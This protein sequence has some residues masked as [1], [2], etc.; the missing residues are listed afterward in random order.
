MVDQ[1]ESLAVVVGRNCKDIRSTIGATQDEIAR[2]ARRIGLRWTASTVGDFEAGRSAPTFATVLAVTLALQM[3]L[4]D[5][6]EKRGEAPDPE[7]GATLADLLG[8]QGQVALTDSFSVPAAQVQAVC[9]GR[10]FTAFDPQYRRPTQSMRDGIREAIA[11]QQG[12]SAEEVDQQERELKALFDNSVDLRLRSGL[13][14]HRLAKRLN[15][16]PAR[17]AIV[18]VQLWQSTFTE[19]RDRRAGP[20]ANQQKRGRISREL[21][22]ELEEA[23]ADGND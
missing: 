16:S 17:L 21:R 15:I 23:L 22:V 18:S 12:L 1:P 19:E 5:A 10:T 3:A 13:T 7:Q 8:E 4:E 11:R 14:E 6:A 9:R 2:C 20:D